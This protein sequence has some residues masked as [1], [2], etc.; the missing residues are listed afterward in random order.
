MKHFVYLDTDLINSYLA[1]LNDG[2]IKSKQEESETSVTEGKGMEDIPATDGSTVGINIP[3]IFKYD[4]EINNDYIKEVNS[5]SQ[6][7]AGREI[8]S[9]IIHDNSYNNLIDYFS[10]TIGIEEYV[11]GTQIDMG[12]Y[13]SIQGNVKMVDLAVFLELFGDDF[14]NVYSLFSRGAF[15][16]S[17]DNLNRA[18]RR[19][20]NEVKEGKEKERQLKKDLTMFGNI[21]DA[22]A[23]ISKL[24]PSD[25]YIVY[26]NILIPLDKKYLREDYN[27]LRYKY[28]NEST[29]VGHITGKV[30]DIVNFTLNED[31]GLAPM[32]Q[33]LDE[34][35]LA[36][37]GVL[38]IDQ[39]F[40]IMHPISWYYE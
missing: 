11:S 12:T 4:H 34:L 32:L 37:F 5:I 33:S 39:D 35:L 31:S 20:S 18:E 3:G 21:N 29:I 28:S 10:N 30:S 19:S 7:N 22:V 17:L 40:K 26:D 8:L 9:K 25:K 38:G 36:A 16:D 6:T 15:D 13:L 2:L 23:Y 1:Q 14:K 27:S 24:L